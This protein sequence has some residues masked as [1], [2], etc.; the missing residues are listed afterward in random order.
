MFP[1]MEPDWTRGPA[2]VVQGKML[3]ADHVPPAIACSSQ[4]LPRRYALSTAG[5]DQAPGSPLLVQV[6]APGL[7]PRKTA[8]QRSTGHRLQPLAVGHCCR[9]DLLA[10]AESHRRPCSPA[11]GPFCG[12]PK[13]SRSNQCAPLT[14]SCP[15]LQTCLLSAPCH[16]RSSP[17]CRKHLGRKETECSPARPRTMSAVRGSI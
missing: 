15:T 3:I 9:Q 6:A 16:N 11:A 2:L 13:Q 12:W 10:Q 17:T 4:L 5:L 7:V 1:R 14:N 8:T